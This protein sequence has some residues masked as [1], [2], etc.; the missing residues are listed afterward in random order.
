[1]TTALMIAMAATLWLGYFKLAIA[2]AA[3]NWTIAMVRVIKVW[4]MTR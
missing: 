3:I 2:L 1:M 4:R